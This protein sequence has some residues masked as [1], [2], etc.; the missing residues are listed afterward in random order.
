M[1]AEQVLISMNRGAK[2]WTGQHPDEK[3]TSTSGFSKEW[4]AGALVKSL[5]EADSR[6]VMA[7]SAHSCLIG[8]GRGG[9]GKGEGLPNVLVFKKI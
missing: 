9:G 8:M 5:G 7:E 3:P 4:V 1:L 2:E 6:V